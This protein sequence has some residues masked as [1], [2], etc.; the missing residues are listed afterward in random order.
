M[1]LLRKIFLPDNTTTILDAVHTEQDYTLV[2]DS[3]G[4]IHRYSQAPFINTD[5]PDT[6]ID[7]STLTSLS[8]ADTD[9]ANDVHILTTQSFGNQRVVALTGEEGTLLV[10]LN[11]TTLSVTGTFELSVASNFVYGASKAQFVRWVNMDNL[12]SGLI[13]L[14]TIANQSAVI[15]SVGLGSVTFNTVVYAANTLL[16]VCDNTFAP[17]DKI[18]IS[19]LTTS[20]STELLNGLTVEVVASLPTGFIAS[21]SFP[22]AQAPVWDVTR[23]YTTGQVVNFNGNPFIAVA[24]VPINTPPPNVSY[25]AVVNG[26]ALSSDVGLAQSQNSGSTFETLVDL[27]ASQ[28]IGTFDKSKLRNQFVA[29]G[30]ILFVPDDT[31]SGG[32]TPPQ[33]LEPTTLMFGGVTQINLAW[34]QL[35]SDLIN[36]YTVQ[37]AV[38]NPVSAEIPLV[39]PFTVT[40]PSINEFTA[41]EGVFDTVTSVPLTRTTAP[42]P[43]VGQY[44]VDETTGTYTFNIAQAGNGIVITIRQEFQNYQIINSGNVQSLFVQL[45]LGRTYFF[46]VQASGLDGTSAFS[47]IV[48]IT[49]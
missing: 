7:V 17:G 42:S 3:Q 2:L 11:T 37:Y 33:L 20:P 36:S 45:P 46:Q 14:G 32:P 13:L 12:H 39:A 47:N 8:F 19:G 35:R 43:L 6:T 28:I 18:V 5:N 24:N 23:T 15:T 49:I 26:I 1:V 38:D 4:Q 25:W 41:D 31:Y 48:S 27:A 29:T 34:S 21:L 40:V 30:E 16:V 10:Q 9:D 22:T 44:F